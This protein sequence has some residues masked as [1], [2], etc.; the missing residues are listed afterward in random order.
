V[1]TEHGRAPNLKAFWRA[2]SRIRAC[3][4]SAGFEAEERFGEDRGDG[5]EALVGAGF[6]SEAIG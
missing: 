4:D 5:G 6:G 2:V 1:D 3:L